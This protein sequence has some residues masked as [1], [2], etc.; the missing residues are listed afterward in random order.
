MTKQCYIALGS[1]LSSAAIL[2]SCCPMEGFD[3]KA[4]DKILGLEALGL[5]WSAHG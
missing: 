3:S 1:L 5:Q 2:E 4:Y